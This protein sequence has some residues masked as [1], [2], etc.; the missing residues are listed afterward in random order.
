MQEQ[1]ERYDNN[2]TLLSLNEA[3]VPD[4][5]LYDKIIVGASIRYGKHRQHVYD[6]V[7]HY[8]SAL[9]FK[10]SA[11]FS[12]NV[13]ARKPNRCTPS[14]NPYVKKFLRKVSWRPSVVAVFAGKIDYQRYRFFDRQMIRLIMWLTNGPT[15]LDAS[16]EFTDW[17][18]VDAFG[19][20]VSRM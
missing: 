5:A 9:N 14:S 6:F 10:P 2:V 17:S 7:Q 20:Q 15:N 12:V 1:I 19:Q 13:V 8:Q 16:V 18:Q 11:F 3:P 4:L